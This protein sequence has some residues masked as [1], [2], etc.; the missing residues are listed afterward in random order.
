MHNINTFLITGSSG[1]IGKALTNKLL[2]LGYQVIPIHHNDN[3]KDIKEKI[4]D[5][6]INCCFLLGWG[7]V[8]GAQRNKQE[9]Q[10][11]NINNIANQIQILSEIN[12]KKI[13]FASSISEFEF[14]KSICKTDILPPISL[15]G[16]S[17]L[18]AHLLVRD[19]CEKNNIQ[20]GFGYIS[21]VYGPGEISDKFI[22]SSI[23]KLIF[24]N[25][26]LEFSSGEQ[27]FDFVYI[28]DVVEDLITL[29]TSAYHGS[30]LIGSGQHKPLK[31]WIH[32]MC[33]VF[34][35]DNDSFIKFGAKSGGESVN[36]SEFPWLKID[37][38]SN[39]AKLQRKNF[40]EGILD[41]ASFL[42][43]NFNKIK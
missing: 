35:K 26:V 10:L 8:N 7:G 11:Q 1:F 32:E 16:G 27:L 20:Y 29:G 17:K 19:F 34:N 42:K 28:D 22:C 39:I 43:E 24:T 40:K 5:I 15:Y 23:K 14:I 41:T 21:A 36:L 30:Y 38:L 2:S 6:Q 12:I 3:I 25:D 13:V 37:F 9:T 33:S 31:H 18:Y 4:K